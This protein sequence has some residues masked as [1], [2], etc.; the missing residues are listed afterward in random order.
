MRFGFDIKHPWDWWKDEG[1]N[2]STIRPRAI[3]QPPQA[4]ASSIGC[5]CADVERNDFSSNHHP[6]PGY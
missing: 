4:C 3:M 5:E 2:R 6:A 1:R